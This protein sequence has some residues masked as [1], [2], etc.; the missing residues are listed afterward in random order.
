MKFLLLAPH[1]GLFILIIDN[2]KIIGRLS[3]LYGTYP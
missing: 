1:S 3:V 2:A